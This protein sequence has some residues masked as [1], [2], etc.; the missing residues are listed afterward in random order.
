MRII[1][2]TGTIGAGK[3]TVSRW[4]GEL[5]AVVIDADALVHRL[6]AEDTALQAHLQARFGAEVVQDGRVHRPTLARIVFGQPDELAALEAIVHP[7][8][9][10]AEDDL[11][12][13]ARAAGTPVCVL[14]AARQVESGGSARCDELWIVACDEATQLRRLAARGMGG[15]EAHRRLT[16]QGSITKW[17]AAFLAESARL[18]RYRPMIILDNSGTESVG[19]AQ[20]HRLWAGLGA[21]EVARD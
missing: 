11:L 8:V 4:L 20:V 9:H 10:R 12:A 1:G 7:V 5:G 19:K 3:S 15:P 6:Y 21:N 14:D 18:S 17:S 2:V 13:A 16:M